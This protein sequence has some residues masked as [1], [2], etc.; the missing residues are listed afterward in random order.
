[1]AEHDE[2]KTSAMRPRIDDD[3]V[4]GHSMRTRVD[5][6]PDDFQ[7][8][9]DAGDDVEGHS[10][11]VRVDGGEDDVEG[12]AQVRRIDADEDDDV[13]GHFGQL[14]SPTSRGE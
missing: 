4:E 8:R 9:A 6:G 10:V 1:M 11:K 7:M 2:S 13:E 14:K 3:D 5:G 12:H